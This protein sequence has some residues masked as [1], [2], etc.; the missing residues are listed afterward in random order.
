MDLTDPANLR[1]AMCGQKGH[2]FGSKVCPEMVAARKT[3]RRKTGQTMADVIK[4][5]IK[6]AGAASTANR[7]ATA[8]AAGP[9]GAHA[10]PRSSPPPNT[11]SG[12]Q[13]IKSAIAQNPAHLRDIAEMAKQMTAMRDDRNQLAS[14]VGQ[15][16]KSLAQMRKEMNELRTR[17]GK[18]KGK[19][20]DADEPAE[21]SDMTDDSNYN[22]EFP[23]MPR[24]DS[25]D[26]NATP[27]PHDASTTRKRT[28]GEQERE[29]SPT[30]RS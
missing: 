29:K 9:P 4:D 20:H 24:S 1:C 6:A 14:M 26:G 28:R 3:L 19:G 15:L 27:Q 7:T 17:V 5:H 22:T 23:P 13:A 10:N 2:M 8:T 16:Q 30:P 12:E 18:R 25:A 21:D 11:E